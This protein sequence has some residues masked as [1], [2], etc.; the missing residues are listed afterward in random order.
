MP[1]L[2]DPDR[3]SRG[4]EGAP[5]LIRHPAPQLRNKSKASFDT[6][7]APSLGLTSRSSHGWRA[8]RSTSSTDRERVGGV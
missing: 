1:D 4:Q 7:P 5:T 8:Y 3:G 2:R 6:W